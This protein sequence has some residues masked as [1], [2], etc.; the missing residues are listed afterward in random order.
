MLGMVC[1]P[2]A[3]PLSR[4]GR[5]MIEQGAIQLSA[6]Q[7]A[8]LNYGGNLIVRAGAGSGKT[9]VL[10]RRF[11]ALIAGDLDGATP[12]NPINLAALTFTEKAALDM[13][14][15]IAS[16]LAERTASA[17]D[18]AQQKHLRRAQRTL[19]LARI[20][21]IHAFCARILRENAVVAGRDPDFA[22]LDDYETTVF[23][24]RI[25]RDVMVAAVRAQDRGALTLVQAR[26]MEGDSPREDALEIV[27]RI[28]LEAR[29]RGHAPKWIV[30][31][32]ER[33][34]N[35]IDDG[36]DRV[37]QHAE[38]FTRLIDELAK[39]PGVG[40][41][42]GD[43]LRE[44]SDLWITVREQVHGLDS[45]SHPAAM[46]VLRAVQQ[47]LPTAAN[48]TTKPIVK[49]I[50]LLL[51]KSSA[52]YGL[53]GEL[54]NAWGEYQGAALARSIARLIASAGVAI[55]EAERI[56]RV[57]TFD[58]LLIEV[59]DL[60]RN[61]PAVIARYRREL[62]AVLVDE[63]QDTNAVQDEIIQL[64]TNPETAH[65]EAPPQ[66]FI[67]GDEK[68]SIYRF[69][70]A[71]V[72]V[73]N[74]PRAGTIELPLTE[75]RRSTPNILKFANGLAA[76]AMKAVAP[77]RPYRVN[78][79]DRH[80][81][82]PTRIV[83]ADYPVEVIAQIPVDG[84]SA[85]KAKRNFVS[86][87]SL[88]ARALAQRIRQLVADGDLVTDPESAL[89]RRSQYRDCVILLRAFG[90][91]A[92]YENALAHAGVPAYT[93]K[94]R[95]F[96]RRPEV[97]DLV[98]LIKVI[99]DPRD[100]MALAAVLRSPFFALSDNCLMA[101]GLYL[102][103]NARPPSASS[104]AGLFERNDFSWLT[105][106][107]QEVE[108]AAAI[109]REL[110]SS[111]DREPLHVVVERALEMT[112][113]ESVMAGLPLGDQR[114][115][116]L[117]K[118]QEIARGFDAHRF[119][120]FHDFARYLTRLIEEEPYEPQAQVPGEDDDVVRIM[121][122]HQAKGLEFPIVIIADAGRKPP[123]VNES[124]LLDPENGL[125]VCATDGSGYDEIPNAALHSYR[126][127]LTDEAE[128][129]SARILYVA[130]T[131][132]RDRLI[133]SEGANVL[134]WARYLRDFIGEENFAR[135]AE[136][137][138]DALTVERNDAQII[139]RRA[140]WEDEGDAAP[141]KERPCY[142]SDDPAPAPARRVTA[143]RETLGDR[144]ISPTALADFDRCPRQ[145]WLRY[146]LGLPEPRAEAERGNANALAMGSVAHTV[147]EQMQFAL[148]RKQSDAAIARRTGIVGR[149]AGLTADQCAAIA[150]DL[151][152]Y[153]GT[154]DHAE[155]ILGREVPFMLNPA[156]G[157]FVRG[158][159]DVVLRAGATIIV[160]D[161]K[162]ATAAEVSRYQIQL[163]CYGLAIAEQFPTS[164]V[165][166]Q[167]A[168]LRERAALIALPMPAIDQI[169]AR[170]GELAGK[171]AEA[172]GNSAYG[173]GPANPATCRK[174]H[175]GYVDRC[176]SD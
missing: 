24:E 49:A 64:L 71:D 149:R 111:R 166:L 50:R 118:L 5:S 17:A 147:L 122:V 101:I 35:R 108:G 6:E 110:R 43:K 91:I 174:L 33:I 55:A 2:D 68:Q 148:E 132:A 39:T 162:Y 159:I 22:I 77:Q 23:C 87:R 133:I 4:D 134:G 69:R 8:A 123:S 28:L 9:E 58:D 92:I 96:Y 99:A 78:W 84:D 21:T 75:N 45:E 172:A 19:G 103:P 72:S 119:F 130:M 3:L 168:V 164:T 136:A 86:K 25:C 67:V 42:A 46:E 82:Q 73:F 160:R 175:C 114:I 102:Q 38:D 121:T 16:V 61:Y 124:V 70:G 65:D 88:E 153:I 74:R 139:V 112:H 150:S 143:P 135:L 14:T 81:L 98:Q 93:V 31:Q 131:R 117:H 90:D 128:A 155:E 129:E 113:Y 26:R 10:A 154:S 63:Y 34:A 138:K 97:I 167:I 32:T 115:A 52:N 171:L 95:G 11:V 169:R 145:Y 116:N 54:I 27:Q 44:L 30:E 59:R 146:G 106:E 36:V 37:A 94:G 85:T 161:Y 127:R 170:L 79:S 141:P 56:N 83:A 152:R 142:G 158:Q 48:R 51:D 60:L 62:R 18:A 76:V 126:G 165:A 107:R 7:Q 20:T 47:A 15:R 105:V 13:R 137:G 163:E 29:R 176:W 173:K 80:A 109:L 89:P 156:P 40:G 41:T 100:S 1:L 140:D 151:V 104:I 53:A 66:L 120:T 12:L 157:L 144:V 57:I 125:I